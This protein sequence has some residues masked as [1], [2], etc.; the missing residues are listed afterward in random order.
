MKKETSP[1][2]Y[3]AQMEEE[4]GEPVRGFAL[5][6]LNYGVQQKG[7]FTPK[8]EWGL[9]FLTDSALFIEHGSTSNWL[10]RL[11]RNRDPEDKRERERIPVSTI[12]NVVIPP[13]LGPLK[14]FLKGPEVSVLV[15]YGNPDGSM[16]LTG[17]AHLTLDRRGRQDRAFI[18]LL[19]KLSGAPPDVHGTD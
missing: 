13:P 18:E 17:E 1:E 8:P 2:E 10:T 11:M 5:A 9:V 6:R 15:Q 19:S 12:T 7:F 16:Q 4:L 3:W 14:A